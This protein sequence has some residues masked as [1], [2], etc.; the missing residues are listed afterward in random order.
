MRRENFVLRRRLFKNE[1]RLKQKYNENADQEVNEERRLWIITR[2]GRCQRNRKI[3]DQISVQEDEEDTR[4]KYDIE[5]DVNYNVVLEVLEEEDEFED[6]TDDAS[7][8]R[9]MK[10][11]AVVRDAIYKA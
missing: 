4:A 7:R 5:A 1:E 11:R 3:D 10:L 8:A 6:E 2:A 9:L